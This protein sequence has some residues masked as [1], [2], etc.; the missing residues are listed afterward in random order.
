MRKA[1]L[2]WMAV[3]IA[4]WPPIATA[5]TVLNIDDFKTGPTVSVLFTGSSPGVQGGSMLGGFRR[6]N[7]TVIPIPVTHPGILQIRPNGPLI[8]SCGYKVAHRLEVVYGVDGS[9]ANAPLNLDLSAYDKLAVD[10][11]ASDQGVNF[12]IVIFWASGAYWAIQGFNLSE[13]N[14]PFTVDFPLANFA[15]GVPSV[16]PDFADID[17][18]VVIAQTGSAIGANDYA[19]SGIRAVG[20]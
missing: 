1:M 15:P 20:P 13:S 16:P 4:V 8:V 17:Y 7:F 5:E 6:T 2:L 10:F 14:V 11:E 12:N 18:I 3:S 9:G 19:I